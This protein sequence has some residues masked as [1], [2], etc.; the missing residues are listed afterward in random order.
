[1]S[2]AAR[3]VPGRGRHPDRVRELRGECAA[4]GIP[5]FFKQWSEWA[6]APEERSRQPM[7]RVGKRDAGPLLDCRTWDEMP[8]LARAE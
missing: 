7:I 3:S 8:A 5:F 1:L 6:A 2:L 4:A